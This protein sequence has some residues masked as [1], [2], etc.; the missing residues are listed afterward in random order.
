[1]D[2]RLM[3][4]ATWLDETIRYC[5]G[6]PCVD[7]Y[8][9]D[10]SEELLDCVNLFRRAIRRMGVIVCSKTT[11]RFLL[12]SLDVVIG[13]FVDNVASNTCD[14]YDSYDDL[15]R[16][17]QSVYEDDHDTVYE[18]LAAMN[19]R[20]LPLGDMLGNLLDCVDTNDEDKFQLFNAMAELALHCMPSNDDLEDLAIDML[21]EIA[22]AGIPNS[23][24]DHVNIDYKERFYVVYVLA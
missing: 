9:V 14:I 5:D 17:A 23:E 1:M 15:F 12:D 21:Q 7:K 3:M 8:Y 2:L 19:E 20:R 11:T 18:D 24:V 4:L 16:L 13:N 22:A 6:V 10:M